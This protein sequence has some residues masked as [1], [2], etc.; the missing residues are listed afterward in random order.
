VLKLRQVLPFSVSL[1]LVEFTDGGG[2]K[3]S[4]YLLSWRFVQWRGTKIY[5]G[6]CVWMCV[7]IYSK[8]SVLSWIHFLF[9]KAIT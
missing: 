2:V 3:P 5:C 1:C 6:L 7:C 4:N 9:W 8:T